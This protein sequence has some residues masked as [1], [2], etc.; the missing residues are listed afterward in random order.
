MNTKYTKF[1]YTVKV[2]FSLPLRRA[3]TLAM[4]D[5]LN[6]PQRPKRTANTPAEAFGQ[7]LRRL[8]KAKGL[9]QT[10]LGDQIGISQ[11]VVTYYEREGGSPSPELLVK[12]AQALGI[13]YEALLGVRRAE[14]QPVENVRLLRRL[15]RIEQLPAQDRRTVLKMIDAL[16]DRAGKRRVG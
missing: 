1:V 16:A 13:S 6:L 11:R 12:F 14:A 8:R 2:D 3:P 7:R 15:K 4:E 10:E 9:T 5:W